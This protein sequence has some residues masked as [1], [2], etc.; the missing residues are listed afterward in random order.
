VEVDDGRYGV[1]VVTVALHVRGF[2]YARCAPGGLY[3][4]YQS[5]LRFV[6]AMA[7][8]SWRPQLSNVTPV[9]GR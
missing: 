2:H 7:R 9:P 3:D 1:G 4:V 8:R 5:R 6:Y